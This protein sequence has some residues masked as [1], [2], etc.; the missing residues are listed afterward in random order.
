MV[1]SYMMSIL[2]I[3]EDNYYRI[4]GIDSMRKGMHKTADILQ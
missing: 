1:K 2:S 4:L 3:G